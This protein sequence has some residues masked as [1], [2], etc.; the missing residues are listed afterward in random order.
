MSHTKRFS[1]DE[2]ATSNENLKQ[3]QSQP[4]ECWK[5]EQYIHKFNAKIT[6]FYMLAC[7]FFS[8]E[9]NAL[10]KLWY[11]Y[12]FYVFEYVFD[13]FFAAFITWR[14]F[15]GLLLW[16]F[17]WVLD[18]N[19]PELACITKVNEPYDIFK[20]N[21]NCLWS[22]Q[23][24]VICMNEYVESCEK[25]TLVWFYLLSVVLIQLKETEVM[26]SFLA[27]MSRRLKVNS[28]IQSI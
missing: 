5:K 4:H 2:R 13:D 25:C 28:L 3:R 10:R 24:T 16:F 12:R 20:C 17:F 1:F 22:T 27:K 19:R 6:I 9:R 7:F 11:L 23:R 26:F 21:M 15:F 18:F 14:R 8:F